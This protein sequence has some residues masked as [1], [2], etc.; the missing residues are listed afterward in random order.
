VD[1]GS[2]G[3]NAASRKVL[4]TNFIFVPSGEVEGAGNLHMNLKILD[5]L[6]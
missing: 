5:F 3:Q 6:A 2:R 4:T 1:L